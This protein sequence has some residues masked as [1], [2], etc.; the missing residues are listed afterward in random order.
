MIEG[1]QSGQGERLIKQE[2]EISFADKI[3]RY[4]GRPFYVEDLQSWLKGNKK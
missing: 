3:H 4:D 2:T 1:N